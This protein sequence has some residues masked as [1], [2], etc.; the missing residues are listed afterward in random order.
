MFEKAVRL[1]L[2]FDTDKGQISCEDLWD[3]PLT[4][5]RGVSLDSIAVSYYQKLRDNANISFVDNN[6]KTDEGDKLCFDIVRYV[7][8]VK[9]KE[10]QD[11]QDEKQSAEKR[12]RILEALA[13]KK[14]EKLGQSSIEEL[15][16]MLSEI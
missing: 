15:E 3:L 16:R 6:T 9:K 11:R 7:I 8:E 4:S 14:D 10:A 1:K 2:R 12:Q 5:K 13:K